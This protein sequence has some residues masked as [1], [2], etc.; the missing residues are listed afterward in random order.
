MVG[1][2]GNEQRRLAFSQ[3]GALILDSA[4]RS[5]ETDHGVT[6][7]GKFSTPVVEGHALAVGWG[8]GGASDDGNEVL[9]G[10]RA[11]FKPLA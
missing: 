11:V 2:L 4:I 7:T 3:A 10:P 9:T 1:G 5:K 8:R 6:S